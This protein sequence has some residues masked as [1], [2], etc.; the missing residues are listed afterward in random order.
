MS[1]ISNRHT[2]MAAYVFGA[3]AMCMTGAAVWISEVCKALRQ[4]VQQERRACQEAKAEAEQAKAKASA[5]AK[6]PALALEQ[7][8]PCGITI[9]SMSRRVKK[10]LGA[11]KWG[12]TSSATPSLPAHNTAC[13]RPASC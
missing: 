13:A 11:A 1:A 3:I 10:T 7:P 12:R 9:P 2:I 4:E 6:A 5:P 8:W